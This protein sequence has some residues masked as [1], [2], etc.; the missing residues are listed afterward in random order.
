VDAIRPVYLPR[1]S[2][3]APPTGKLKVAAEIAIP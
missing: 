2:T 3:L 1:R